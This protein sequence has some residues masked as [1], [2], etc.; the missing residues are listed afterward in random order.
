MAAR[1]PSIFLIYVDYQVFF[2]LMQAVS[3]ILFDLILFCNGVT[4][5]SIWPWI[6]WGGIFWHYMHPLCL[7]I[8]NQ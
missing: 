6:L 5:C 8:C 3:C 2:R 4:F 7:A 1:W